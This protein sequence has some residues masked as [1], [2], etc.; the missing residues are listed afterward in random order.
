[1][2]TS[3]RLSQSL[4]RQQP[5]VWEV[6]IYATHVVHVCLFMNMHVYIC[7]SMWIH[8][9]WSL[10]MPKGKKETLNFYSRK[11]RRNTT[12]HVNLQENLLFSVVYPELQGIQEVVGKLECLFSMEATF[13]KASESCWWTWDQV[14]LLYRVLQIFFCL[15]Y[16]L[17]SH[18]ERGH[19]Q[20]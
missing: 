16:G 18:Y 17:S 7:I 13:S 11:H 12:L 5:L 3:S 20:I 9:F 8:V 15:G 19:S 10:A 14:P 1:M 4:Q 2:Q 6:L